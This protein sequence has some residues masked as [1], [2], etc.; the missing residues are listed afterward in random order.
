MLSERG[1][2]P[3][4]SFKKFEHSNFFKGCILQILLFSI[5]EYFVSYIILFGLFLIS[6]LLPIEH[7]HYVIMIGIFRTLSNILDGDL[8][9]DEA[10]TVKFFRKS[11]ILDVWHSSEYTFESETSFLWEKAYV[12]SAFWERNFFVYW[13]HLK[14]RSIRPMPKNVITTKAV[15]SKCSSKQVF[16]KISPY[17]QENTCVWVSF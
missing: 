14:K 13:F 9:I 1:L 5:F 11:F 3:E 16:L 7:I 6:S 10:S 15:V 8:T 12:K 4:S 17:S 2:N